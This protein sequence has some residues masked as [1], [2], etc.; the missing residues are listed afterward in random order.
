V[1]ISIVNYIYI[2]IPFCRKKCLYCDFNSISFDSN[3]AEKYI[4]AIIKEI[5]AQKSLISKIK[6][7]YIGGGTPTVLKKDLLQ[8]LI[9]SITDNYEVEEQ[10]EITIE[11]NPESINSENIENIHSFGINRISLGIQSLINEDLIM[12]GRIHNA[13]KAIEALNLIKAS[14][15]KNL[16]VD[17]IYGIA[18]ELPIPSSSNEDMLLWQDTLLKIISINPEHISLYELTPEYDTPLYDAVKS[19]RLFMPDENLVAEMYYSAKEILE[20]F[21][22]IHYEISNFAK[23]GYECRHNLNYW[24]GKDYIGIGAGAHSFVKGVRY[25]NMTDVSGYITAIENKMPTIIESA[26]LTPKEQFNEL[27]FL[28]LRQIKG[29]EI[30]RIPQNIFKEM[31]PAIKELIDY[32]LLDIKDNYLRLTYKGLILSS[33]V[34]LRLIL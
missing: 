8:K 6:T 11:A 31:E 28:G 25:S 18:R 22:Y 1:E 21:G 23:S 16:S 29:L 17:L 7:I 15:F 32:N 26:K 24:G 20:K 19:N 12:L 33:Y 13:D 27:I 30:N 10:V 3:V 2:H 9:T 4:A 34:M 14:T 5:V